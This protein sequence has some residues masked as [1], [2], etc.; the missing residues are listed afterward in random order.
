MANIPFLNNAYF[1]GTVGI[2]TD[3]PGA[4]LDVV[5]TTYANAFV[6]IQDLKYT[7]FDVLKLIPVYLVL[8]LTRE[9]VLK[10]CVLILQATSG[11]GRIVLAR[12]L[13]LKEI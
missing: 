13:R 2:G 10:E 9:M 1:A 7:T 5:T 4:K 8:Q 3:S 11:L 6:P 12:S